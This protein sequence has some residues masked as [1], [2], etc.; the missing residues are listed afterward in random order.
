MASG[1][2][3]LIL[4]DGQTGEV[5]SKEGRAIIS[6][7]PTGTGFPWDSQWQQANSVGDGGGGGGGCEIQ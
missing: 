1:I 7:D 3:M 6:Q 2:P 4:L 5:I